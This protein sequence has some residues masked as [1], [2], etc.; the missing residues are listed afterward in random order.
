M[1]TSS[2]PQLRQA[3]AAAGLTQQAL[4]DLLGVE[5][6]HVARWE[7]GTLPLVDRA[8]EIASVLST[9]VE[10]I[11]PGEPVRLTP[12]AQRDKALKKHLENKR[13]TA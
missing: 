9:T 7:A 1:V 10:A 2:H 11:W 12:V 3:R 4:A 5:Q 8:V 6:P 13:R